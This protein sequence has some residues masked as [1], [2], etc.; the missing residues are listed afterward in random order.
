MNY[1]KSRACKN[2]EGNYSDLKNFFTGR[3]EPYS[4][5]A[6]LVESLFGLGCLTDYGASCL[7]RTQEIIRRS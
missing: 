3:L 4:K 5:L 6:A 2:T 1:L 7:K